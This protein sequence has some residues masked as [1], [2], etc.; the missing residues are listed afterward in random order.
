MQWRT[1][2]KACGKEFL[3]ILWFLSSLEIQLEQSEKDKSVQGCE[4]WRLIHFYFG[5]SMGI[6]VVMVKA[7]RSESDEMGCI[8]AECWNVLQP[9]GHFAW[10]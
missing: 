8:P 6:Y 1:S 9:F 10:P 3:Y 7:S 5:W 4:I 2:K